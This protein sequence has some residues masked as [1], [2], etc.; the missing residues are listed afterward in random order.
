[1]LVLAEDGGSGDV[2]RQVLTPGPTEVDE[3]TA[4]AVLLPSELWPDQTFA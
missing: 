4:Y 1:M 2:W 3:M